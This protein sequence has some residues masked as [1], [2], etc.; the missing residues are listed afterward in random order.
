MSEKELSKYY[1][2]KK[3]IKD[4][5]DRIETLGNGVGSIKIT[6]MPK[7]STKLGSIQEKI[8]ELK[9][10][11]VNARLTALEEYLKIETYI[12][13]IEDT[14]I[15]MIARYRYLDLLGWEQ[16]ALKMGNG[17]DRTTISKKM[18][19]FLDNSPNSHTA[20]IK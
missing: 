7:G 3:E 17:Q 16:I 12:N 14:E 8:V 15:R 4:L 10:K 20:I 5:E 1:Y 2:L 13:S 6:D 11:W 9:E 19:K 18:R